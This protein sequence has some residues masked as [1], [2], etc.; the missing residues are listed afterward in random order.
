MI[1]LQSDTF[2]TEMLY[3]VVAF[4]VTMN[5]NLAAAPYGQENRQCEGQNLCNLHIYFLYNANIA[6]PD[7]DIAA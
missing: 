5:I 1:Y 6:E 2:G 4:F 7:P 3:K